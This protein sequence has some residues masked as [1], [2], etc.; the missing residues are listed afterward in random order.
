MPIKRHPSKPTKKQKPNQLNSY[1]KYSGLAIQMTIT[2][3]LMAFIG[4]KL[5]IYFALKFP[6]FLL[7]LVFSSLFGSI[8][9]L[10]K[11]LQ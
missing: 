4:Y 2:I 8:Y 9:L 6:V 3:G 1:L 7:V 11:S 5:D 10:Y